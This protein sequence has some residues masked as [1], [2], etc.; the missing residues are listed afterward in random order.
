MSPD[1]IGIKS[2]AEQK[3]IVTQ[4]YS[5][6]GDGTTELIN[7]PLVSKIGAAHNK[8]GAQVALSWPYRHGVPLS[9]KSTSAKHLKANLDI[10][11]WPLDAEELNELDVATSPAG[12]ASFM[13]NK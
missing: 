7:G 11:A 13:C 5:P 9:T 8:T 6:L 1:P 12:H 4:S 2:Y 3:G 10:F